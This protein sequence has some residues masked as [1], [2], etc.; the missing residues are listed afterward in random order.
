MTAQPQ[1]TDARLYLDLFGG[2]TLSHRGVRLRLGKKQCAFLAY[3]ALTADG[4]ATRDRLVGVLWSG[5]SE[6][7]AK[8][9]APSSPP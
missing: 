8:A 6:A 3:L 2:V 7:K 9:N 5:S 4:G 1:P